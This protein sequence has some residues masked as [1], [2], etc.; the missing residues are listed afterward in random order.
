MILVSV[1]AVPVLMA[2]I[3]EDLFFGPS[4]LVSSDW[5]SDTLLSS[6][7][8]TVSLANESRRRLGFS[9]AGIRFCESGRG[10]GDLDSAKRW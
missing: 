4:I 8:E 7:E 9:A 6:V 1:K 10:L 3:A 2:E 5:S